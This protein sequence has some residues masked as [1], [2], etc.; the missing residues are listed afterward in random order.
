MHVYLKH[1]RLEHY[2]DKTCADLSILCMYLVNNPLV[3]AGYSHHEINNVRK[4][5]A[6]VMAI[7][8]DFMSKGHL[9]NTMV[10][11]MGDHGLRW[12]KVRTHV[13]GKLE[14]RLPLFAILT[15]PWF[16]SK[17]P[18]IMANLK[19][20]RKRLTS[21]FDV[22]A[23][24]RHLL[25]YPEPPK[26]LTRGQS[27]F[28]E[29]PESR[30][31]K[32]A[33]TVDHWCPCLH[34]QTVDTKHIHVQKAGLAVVEYMN[35]LLSKNHASS[36]NCNR[37]TLKDINFAQLERPNE[38]VVNVH[39]NSMSAFKQGEEYFCRYQLQLLTSPNEGLFE[40]TVKYVKGKFIVGTSIS[41][42]NVYGD[43]PKCIAAKLPHVRKF[44]LCKS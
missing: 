14:E 33:G 40:A 12:G 39:L 44:C 15:P 20:N 23:T 41:R 11:L 7:L 18:E 9:N 31:C 10:I 13:Q 6:Y 34:W 36:L 1:Y 26:D 43:Q 19:K 2:S 16:Q 42:I 5:E 37:L 35:N 30:T 32:D 21:W 3:L 4:N 25:S 29:V 28:Y 27:L 22:Y 8:N 38:A 24:F 17:Y